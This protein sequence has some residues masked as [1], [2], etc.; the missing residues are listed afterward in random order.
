MTAIALVSSIG[1][2]D[3]RFEDLSRDPGFGAWI[4]TDYRVVGT[5]RAYGIMD[6]E[7]PENGVKFIYLMPVPGIGGP[8]VIFNEPVEIGSVVH[9]R[10]V[11][12]SYTF[13]KT[14]T[15]LVGSLTGTQLPSTAEVRID[16]GL[17]PGNSSADGRSLNPALYTPVK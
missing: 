13:L 2:G 12:R 7:L 9:I 14:S 11:F 16:L 10:G 6:R 17:H 4:G 8:E 5:I 15:V 3:E 1:C